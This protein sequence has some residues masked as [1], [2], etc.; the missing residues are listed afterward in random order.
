MNR[1]TKKI[2]TA[3]IGL[4]ALSG[5]INDVQACPGG[6]GGRGFGGGYGGGFRHGGGHYA[7]AYSQPRYIQPAPQP[8]YQQPAYSPSYAQP[9]MGSYGNPGIAQPNPQVTV[10]QN[11]NVVPNQLPPTVKKMAGV[12]PSGVARPHSAHGDQF[13]AQPNSRQSLVQ[14]PNQQIGIQGQP[15]SNN[16]LQALG[17]DE[18]FQNQPQQGPTGSSPARQTARRPQSQPVQQ[19]QPESQDT[20]PMDQAQLSALQ[21]LAGFEGEEPQQTEAPV[22]QPQQVEGV[23][24]FEEAQPVQAAR[25]TGRPQG[26]SMHVG[27]WSASLQNGSK[28][29][30]TLQPNGNFTWV[31]TSGEKVSSFE[32]NYTIGNGS[33]TL[34]RSSDNQKLIGAMTPAGSN[35]FSFKLTG[36]KD[37]GLNFSRS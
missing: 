23:E 26:Q 18:T 34:V 29:E 25:T 17:G 21:A 32:G 7:P 35:S 24:S 19:A 36:T 30:L 37:A 11:P 28:V 12:R 27:Q 13:A 31:A 14:S 6:G 10:G 2:A 5:A 33:L 3:L 1:L 15:A 22:E 8:Y 20:S 16:P 9:A 4:G